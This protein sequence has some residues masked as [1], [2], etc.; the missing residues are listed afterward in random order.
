MSQEPEI[1]K[2][3]VLKKSEAI[4]EGTPQVKGYD[5]NDGIDYSKLFES[6]VNTGFQATNLG[7]AIREINKMVNK[8]L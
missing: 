8:H 6:Y 5:F 4:A 1:A 7:L 2:D 3:A